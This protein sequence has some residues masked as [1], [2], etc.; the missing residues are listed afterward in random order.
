MPLKNNQFNFKL[1]IL[2]ITRKYR[3]TRTSRY[4]QKLIFTISFLH[5]KILK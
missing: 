4:V 2:Q 3:T 5:L 1:T